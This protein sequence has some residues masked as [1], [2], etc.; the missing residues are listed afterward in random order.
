MI[1]WF[2]H[3]YFLKQ[4]FKSDSERKEGREGLYC[5]KTMFLFMHHFLL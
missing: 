1:A 5:Y 4:L 2:D 3:F